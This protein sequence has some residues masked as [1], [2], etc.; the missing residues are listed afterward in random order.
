MRIKGFKLNRL[1]L[2]LI[3]MQFFTSCVPEACLEET[4]SF[5][6][7]TFYKSATYKPIA[8]DSVTVF[9]IG[10]DDNKLYNKAINTLSI[11]LPLDASSETCGFVIRINGA[12]D[13]LRFTYSNYPHLI[14]KACGITFFHSLDT[15]RLSVRPVNSIIITNKNI[16]TFNEENIR[17]L[18]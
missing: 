13:T 8:P 11:K 5:L 12:T 4:T 18:Y 6:N 1:F 7:A 10:K 2:L 3:L 16:A 14:S 15:F 17:I 9:G